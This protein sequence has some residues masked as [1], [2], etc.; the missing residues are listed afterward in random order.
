MSPST[1]ASINTS[2]FEGWL[3]N[4]LKKRILNQV[5]I[6]ISYAALDPLL[7]PLPTHS[8]VNWLQDQSKAI[9]SFPLFKMPKQELF[10][11]LV[12]LQ[13]CEEIN[14]VSTGVHTISMTIQI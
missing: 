3:T 8:S 14:C 7:P 13:G 10:K 5:T 12:L 1:M 11:L 6:N 2:L 9:F 4:K